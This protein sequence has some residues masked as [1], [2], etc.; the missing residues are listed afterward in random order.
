[1]HTIVEFTLIICFETVG[2]DMLTWW[3]H[4]ELFIWN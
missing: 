2:F 3:G 4:N 1:M